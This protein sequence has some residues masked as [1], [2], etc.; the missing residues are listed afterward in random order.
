MTR[1]EYLVRI[2]SPAAQVLWDLED[3]GLRVDRRLRWRHARRLRRREVQIH[4][5]IISTPPVAAALEYQVQQASST[6]TV[7]ETQKSSAETELNS[8]RAAWEAEAAAI[9]A[10][11]AA[12]DRSR[13][14]KSI[15]RPPALT[16]RVDL[17]PALSAARKRLTDV[18]A[19]FNPGST[20]Q[21][22]W[23]LYTV[24]GLPPQH[25]QDKQRGTTSVTTDKNALVRLRRHDLALRDPI[26]REVLDLLLEYEHVNELRTTF[27]AAPLVKGPTGEGRFVTLYGLHR[28]ATGRIA[29]GA[30]ADEKAAAAAGNAQNIPKELRDMFLPEPGNLL[31][32]VD[33]SK[34]EWLLTLMFAGDEGG[35]A[36]A[37]AGEDQHRRLAAAIFGVNYNDVTIPQ[38]THAKRGVHGLNYGMGAQKLADTMGISFRDARGV[39]QAFKAAFPLVATW[40]DEVV[41]RATHQHYLDTPFGWRRWFWSREPPE[42]IAFLPSATGADM[43]K[44][45]LPAAAAAAHTAGGRL[46]TTTHDSILAEVPADATPGLATSLQSI[47]QRP[48]RTLGD[49]RFPAEVKTGGDWLTVS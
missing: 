23:L 7:L 25:N 42:M 22:A 45:R 18:S 40:R 9:R 28:T 20:T 21:R 19:G 44:A 31:V 24:F 47:F 2:M 12:G 1:W 3:V 37:I 27:L 16:R 30:D 15:G 32:Q 10:A 13:T 5:Q 34:V 6:V 17:T 14:L 33:W 46:L 43:L 29:S 36:R 38:R 49:R 39:I 8:P 4:Q 26:I 35:W 11:R 48:F 41:T